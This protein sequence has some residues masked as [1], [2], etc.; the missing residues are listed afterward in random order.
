MNFFFCEF[1]N[2]IW[3]LM[4]ESQVFNENENVA[5]AKK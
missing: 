2:V 3:L 5:T 1:H 4:L